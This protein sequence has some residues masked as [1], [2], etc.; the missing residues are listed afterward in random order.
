MIVIF[1]LYLLLE[2]SLDFFFNE[3]NLT[4][5]SILASCWLSFVIFPWG[6]RFNWISFKDLIVHNS[7]RERNSGEI[8]SVGSLSIL[9]LLLL[10]WSLNLI[11]LKRKEKRNPFENFVYYHQLQY[12]H[13]HLLREEKKNEV[14][15]SIKEKKKEKKLNHYDLNKLQQGQ[16]LDKYRLKFWLT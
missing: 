4:S 9:L 3:W 8:Y 10:Y 7:S 5:Q 13:H 15:L 1:Y 12:H 11:S 2:K 14:N 16:F 6:L